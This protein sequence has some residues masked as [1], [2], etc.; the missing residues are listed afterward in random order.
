MQDAL[1]GLQDIT[2]GRILNEE[3]LTQLLLDMVVKPN[4]NI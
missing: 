2:E 3:E 1:L 4:N